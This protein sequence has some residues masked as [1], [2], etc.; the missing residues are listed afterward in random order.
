MQAPRAW[1]HK[2]TCFLKQQC[3][4]NM[5]CEPR[6]FNRWKGGLQLITIYIEDLLLVVASSQHEVTH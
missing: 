5:A 6:I 3:F 2:L 4:V 1:Y